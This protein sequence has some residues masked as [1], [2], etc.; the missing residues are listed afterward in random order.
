[1]KNSLNNY[2]WYEH[3]SYWLDDETYNKVLGNKAANIPISELVSKHK[4]IK[5]ITNFVDIIND[6]GASK[7]KVAFAGQSQ[8]DGKTLTV[9][10][11]V[12]DFDLLAGLSLHEASHLQHSKDHFR[13]LGKL[14]SVVSTGPKRSSDSE[15]KFINKI[16]DHFNSMKLNRQ[17]PTEYLCLLANFV[18]DARIDNR[19]I[20]RYP[21]YEP[22]YNA[23]NRKYVLSDESQERLLSETGETWKN[24]LMKI[25]L[26][27]DRNADLSIL[28]GLSEIAKL[29]DLPNINRLKGGL[30]VFELSFNIFKVIQ[31]YVDK[32][33]Q[34]N[35]QPN[36]SKQKSSKSKSGQSSN[37][38]MPN[39]DN[40]PS[41]DNEPGESSKSDT[42][43]KK[44]KENENKEETNEDGSNTGNNDKNED[45]EDSDNDES[46]DNGS[47]NEDE[48]EVEDESKPTV[49]EDFELPKDKIIQTIIDALN[50]EYE[51]EEMSANEA[52]A[53]DLITNKSVLTR[54]V[55]LHG[56][57]VDTIL[58]KDVTNEALLAKFR[59]DE[60][61][62]KRKVYNS[63]VENGIKK[64]KLLAAR[65]SLMNDVKRVD[66][67]RKEAGSLDARLLP[68]FGHGNT[69]IFKTSK[70]GK[71]QDTNIHITIDSSGSMSGRN[72]GNALE[73]ATMF[74]VA[75]LYIKGLTVQISVRSTIPSILGSDTP[76][77]AIVFDTL[78][79][80]DIKHIKKYM[81]SL[82]VHYL[83]PEGLTFAVI[84]DYIIERSKTKN[85]L[86]IN[87]S[88]GCPC[89]YAGT[90]G[91]CED[92]SGNDAIE[93][94]AKQ[95]NEIVKAGIKVISFFIGSSE[96][97]HQGQQFKRMYGKAS[98]YIDV[99]QPL[100]VANVFNKNIKKV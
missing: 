77:V 87:V 49:D 75:S 5:T 83:T 43:D 95:V 59:I 60:L 63:Y 81:G 69:K 16:F 33:K 88:D 29:V 10:S 96:G 38:S 52:N 21:G 17:A 82:A 27:V 44:E 25:L 45:T 23:L 86:F 12:E 42:N 71:Y 53:Y 39:M 30:D 13:I 54:T 26:L 51:K 35:Q 56:T 73:M 2:K 98:Q 74:A 57:N 41:D 19:T 14:N 58:I 50:N 79:N 22:Y 68:E 62:D 84:K 37:N 9:S 20:S 80:H 11:D 99:V 91:N 34:Q 94:T 70:D 100:K 1:L 61:F 24:Y 28:K 40:E 4:I 15:F 48:S 65:L 85:S 76:F 8:T 7:I 3:S 32:P 55:K 93:F 89:C 64:G 66:A 18:E 36:A 97:S 72:Y 92:F 67:I 6:E 46:N 31:K 78:E 47:D 90:N